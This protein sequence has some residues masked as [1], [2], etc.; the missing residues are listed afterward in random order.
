LQQPGAATTRIIVQALVSTHHFTHVG[1]LNQRF[2][3]RE[4]GFM[5][6]ARVKIIDV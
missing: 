4:I 6:I 1:F 3:S 5:Q 2:E